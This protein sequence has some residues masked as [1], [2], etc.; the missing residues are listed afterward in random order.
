[1]DEPPGNSF[2]NLFSDQSLLYF[3]LTAVFV[4]CSAWI[5]S[6]EAALFALNAD[7]LERFKN[8][9]DNR[10]KT[11]ID[12]LTNPRLLLNVLTAGKYTTLVASAIIPV[13]IFS[14]TQSHKNLFHTEGAAVVTALTAAFALVGVILAKI[15]G[16]TYPVSVARK[17]SMACKRMV[18]LLKPLVKHLIRNSIKVERKLEA[19][20]EEKS[21]EELTRVLQL[22]T[23]DNEPVEGEKEILEGIVNFGTL[24]VKQVMRPKSDI[25]YADFSFNFY[26]LLDFIIK[27]GYSRVP[28]CRGSLDRIAGFLYIKDLLPFLKESADFVWQK[29]LRPSYLVSDSKKVD[30]L[31][32]DFQ[33][34]RVHMALVTNAHNNV[35]GLITLEDIIEEIIGDFNDEFDEPGQRYQKLSDHTFVFDGK[36]S[37]YE[38]CKVLQINPAEFQPVKGINESLNGLL[39]EVNEKLPSMGEHIVIEPFTF[40]IESVDHKRIKKIRVQVNEEKE[41]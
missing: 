3:V 22:A 19:K 9:T 20:T 2:L 11:V 28:V 40:V 41:N 32:K 31:L 7:D 37:L 1:M 23:V 34:K 12:L 6:V 21:V 35:V 15:H 17:N 38:F 14:Y 27:S 29:L 13:L 39:L 25:S 36:T 8:S 26:Q 18:S 16:T 10:E 4:F 24:T 33:E 30:F 5:S